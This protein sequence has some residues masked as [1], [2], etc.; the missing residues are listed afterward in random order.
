VLLV[1]AVAVLHAV[2][3]QQIPE[4][5]TICGYRGESVAGVF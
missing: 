2:Y 1:D 4:P 5:V 3:A